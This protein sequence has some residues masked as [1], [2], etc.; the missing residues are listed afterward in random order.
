MFCMKNLKHNASRQ[1]TLMNLHEPL[2]FN[3][4]QFVVNLVSSVSRIYK[5]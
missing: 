3:G 4:D 5:L 1:A 2:T